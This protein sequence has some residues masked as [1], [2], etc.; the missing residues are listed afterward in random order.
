MAFWNRKREKFPS[1][2]DALAKVPEGF[3]CDGLSGGFPDWL[4]ARWKL[5]EIDGP[6]AHEYCT[7][8]WP[9]GSRTKR[10]QRW[11]DKQLRAHARE[12]LPWFLPIAPIVLY[13]GTTLGGDGSFDTCYAENPD[14]ATEEQ[15]LDGLCR[16]GMPRPAWQEE[17]AAGGPVDG[18]PRAA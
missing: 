3:V 18:G 11:A 14:D 2:A 16:H 13:F 8:C 15:Q 1:V 6:H 4:Y 12:R 17:L 10:K 5:T 9:A 7:R